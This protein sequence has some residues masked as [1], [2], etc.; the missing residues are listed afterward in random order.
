[1]SEE[2][3]TDRFDVLLVDPSDDAT[4]RIEGITPEPIS[5]RSGANAREGL[6]V[7]HGTSIDC[8]V[9]AYELP[10]MDGLSFLQIV[11]AKYPNLPF[12]L[13]PDDVDEE[14]AS[15]AINTGVTDYFPKS[16]DDSD[17][18]L[19]ERIEDAV[20]GTDDGGVSRNQG[21]LLSRA[22]EALDDSFYLLNED[23]QFILWNETVSENTGYTDDEIASRHPTEFFEGDDVDRFAAAMERVLDEGRAKVEAEIV[24]DDGERIPTEY[25]NVRLTDEDGD[26]IGICGIGR[27]ITERKRRE[28]ALREREG[29][30]TALHNATRPLM[31]AEMREEIS[32]IAVGTADEVLDFSRI[33]IY[34]FDRPMD[35]LRPV[36][37]SFDDRSGGDV[38][39]AS[40]GDPVWDV[41]LEDE[42]R[43][44]SD[45]E[46]R[47]DEPVQ[48]A[49]F[50]SGMMIPLG[51]HGVFVA[52]DTAVDTVDDVD[53]EFAELLAATTEAALD[54]AER[55]RLLRERD[56]ELDRRND[57][58]E[59]LNRINRVIRDIDRALVGATSRGE[60]EQEVCERL[61]ATDSYRLAWIG[62]REDENGVSPRSRAGVEDGYLNR[63]TDGSASG[64][65][66]VTV[67]EDLEPRVVE[68]I[69]QDR[70]TVRWRQEALKRGYR[71]VIAVPIVYQEAT[72]G[73]LEVYADQLDAF[74]DETRA[75]LAELGKTIGHAINSIN[76]KD[77]LLS[78]QVIQLD[79]ELRDE[80]DFWVRLAA[81]MRG[82]LEVQA[83]IPQD[84]GSYRGF[85]SVEDGAPEQFVETASRSP[86]VS[87]VTH[88]SDHD[89]ASLYECHLAGATSVTTLADYGA[90]P[91]RVIADA[92]GERIVA[93]VPRG[94]DISAFVETFTEHYPSAEL[95]AR[96]ERSEAEEIAGTFRDSVT[97]RLT[98][99]QQEVLQIA[100]LRGFFDW[101]R[102]VTGEELADSLGVVPSTFH[103]HLRAGQRKLMAVLFD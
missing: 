7:L 97:G 61:V 87:E 45:V 68:D 93:D 56:S 74:H 14:L 59:E 70:R 23:G 3:T 67:T 5:V 28:Q 65:P 82:T 35:V 75:V 9:S 26:L 91:R 85:V 76:R 90:V 18:R 47:D 29:M 2:T 6:D 77:A 1:M 43:L 55:E 60:I 64:P 22:F 46:A 21:D 84:G 88:V 72:Y 40:E 69:F 53:V 38:S 66:A 62:E 36:A 103:Q 20:T 98:D 94:T 73:V 44:Y 50:R 39:L 92:E 57:Q 52:G 48:G 86:I 89:G 34:L 63:V 41:Y 10:D 81:R 17:R 30:L 8:I 79:F 99:R 15:K 11:R 27:D 4:E 96:R 101:P 58:L 80:N 31:R 83:L 32:D 16:S 51:D 33:A 78:E 19:A 54:R 12:I 25:T 71:S 102:E 100:Y 49:P 13:Y 24:T 42:T 95:V 37:R